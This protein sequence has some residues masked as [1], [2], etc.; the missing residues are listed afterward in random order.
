MLSAAQERP[1]LAIREE[2][3]SDQTT[4]IALLRELHH[5]EKGDECDGEPSDRQLLGLVER[6]ETFVAEIDGRL[7]GLV[8]VEIYEEPD[9]VRA[10]ERLRATIMAIAV[11]PEVRRRGVGAQLV[12]HARRWLS[13]QGVS[14]VGLYVR[15]DNAGA[16]AFYRRL[17][18]ATQA[19]AMRREV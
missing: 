9:F 18:F 7:V 5:S 10:G 6:C 14:S 11:A 3:P 12:A 15:A 8:S 13:A 17:G 4:L 19:L 16:Q 2:R 1:R